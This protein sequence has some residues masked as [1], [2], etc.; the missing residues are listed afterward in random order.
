MITGKELFDQL[1]DAGFGGIHVEKML[2]QKTISHLDVIIKNLKPKDSIRMAFMASMTG[3]NG[4]PHAY[5]ITESSLLIGRKKF[6]G[7]FFESI[8]LEDISDFRVVDITTMVNNFAITTKS[9]TLKLSTFVGSARLIWKRLNELFPEKASVPPPDA[10]EIM[11]QTHKSYVDES[12]GDIILYSYDFP[13]KRSS[14]WTISGGTIKILEKPSNTTR[15]FPLGQ[16]YDLQVTSKLTP[17]LSFR[18]SGKAG[19]IIA[20][21]SALSSL[22]A[23]TI[24]MH[25]NDMPIVEQFQKHFAEFSAK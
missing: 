25:K 5:I 20:G 6:F 16:I 8:P 19:T 21:S 18:V 1:K 12:T 15:M 13:E 10:P 7:E 4:N 3:H 11:P 2:E 23:E 24:Y 14:S 9:G 17:K 22:D